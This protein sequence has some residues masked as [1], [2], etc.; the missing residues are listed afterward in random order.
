[1]FFVLTITLYCLII[2]NVNVTNQFEVINDMF[3]NPAMWL[4]I[5]S[6]FLMV[7]VYYAVKAYQNKKTWYFVYQ[8]SCVFIFT[9]SAYTDVIKLA[10]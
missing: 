9:W 6:V 2:V 3:S 1:M 7:S 8:V 5:D 4:F 10:K